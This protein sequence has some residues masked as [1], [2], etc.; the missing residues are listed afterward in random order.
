MSPRKSQK[1]PEAPD[2]CCR[3]CAYHQVGMCI[4]TYY[5]T[6]DHNTCDEYAFTG[7]F[8]HQS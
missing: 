4:K 1:K 3:T 5:S 7:T 6:E 8:K 2:F